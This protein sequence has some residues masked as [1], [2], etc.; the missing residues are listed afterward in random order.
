MVIFQDYK[1]YKFLGLITFLLFVSCSEENKSPVSIIS[2]SRTTEEIYTQA[3]AFCHDRGMAGAPIY[4]NTFSW[5]QRVD[6]GIDTLTYNV[7]YGLNAMPAMGLCADCT[8]EELRAVVQYM[9]DSLD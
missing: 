3:C 5:G 6:K 2:E 1:L 4:A 9:L 8:D 7:K